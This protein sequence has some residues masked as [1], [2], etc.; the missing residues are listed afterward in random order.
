MSEKNNKGGT[1]EDEG[2]SETKL[3]CVQREHETRA[4]RR[5]SEEQE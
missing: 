3:E 5:Q 4:R 2:R 1:K